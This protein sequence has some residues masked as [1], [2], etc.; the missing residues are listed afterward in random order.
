MDVLFR[1]AKAASSAGS[2]SFSFI[3]QIACRFFWLIG[4]GFFA[5]FRCFPVSSLPP[6]ALRGGQNPHPR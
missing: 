6:N 5:A 2:V 4:A 1:R 3:I